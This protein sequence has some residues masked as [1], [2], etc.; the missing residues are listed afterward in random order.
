V[1][2]YKE[3]QDAALTWMADENDT[4]LMRSLVKDALQQ[5]HKQLLL[6]DQYDFMLWPQTE[7]LN[8]VSGRIAYALHPRFS[9]P[10]FVYNPTTDQYLEELAARSLLESGAEWN[11]G[12]PSEVERFM[13][14]GI[15]KWQRQP[16]AAGAITITTTGGTETSSHSVVLTGLDSAGAWVEEELS[17]LNSWSTLTSTTSF[18]VLEDATK[19]GSGWTRALTFTDA[20]ANTLLT[21]GAADYGRQYRMLEVIGTPAAASTLLYRF[22]RIPRD[23][24]RDNDI[25][26]LPATFDDILVLRTLL[27]MQGYSRATQDEMARWRG[28]LTT[29]E[30]QLKMSYQQTRSLGGRPTYV[31]YIPRG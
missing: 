15:S 21:L 7:T 6:E 29:L 31:R 11:D 13:L 14:T 9:Q 12:T 2:T 22:Y 28:R 23:L 24:T 25:P 26:D 3:L 20:S 18:A 4:G 8:V 17:S 30:Q 27:D 19:V 1:R 16:S 5:H 10:L